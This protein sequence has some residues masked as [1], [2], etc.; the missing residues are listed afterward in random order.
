MSDKYDL[1]REQS[2]VKEATCEDIMMILRTMWSR[3]SDIACQ[4]RLRVAFHSLVILGSLGFRPGTIMN[5]PYN[6]VRLFLFRS[7]D[8]TETGLYAEIAIHHNKQKAKAIRR[9][10]DYM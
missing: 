5:L 4:P 7:E 9:K 10:Q 8:H 6:Q 2:F 3:A 1:L